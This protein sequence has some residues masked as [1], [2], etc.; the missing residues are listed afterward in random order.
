[1]EDLIAE[2]DFYAL[3]QKLDLKSTNAQAIVA[4]ALDYLIENLYNKFGYLK[5]L[6]EEPQKEIRHTLL[7][8]DI[9]DSL[10]DLTQH[11]ANPEALREVREHIKLLV[12][13]NRPVIVSDIVEQFSKQPYGWPEWEIV[14]LVAR[15]FMAREL[16]IIQDGATVEPK[17]AVEPMTKRAGWKTL[18]LIQRRIPTKEEIEKAQKLGKELFGNPGSDNADD[19]CNGLRGDLGKWEADLTAWSQLAQTGEYP[20]LKIIKQ[21]RQ[22]I[23]GVTSVKDTFEFI[24]AF[25]KVRNELLNASEDIFELHEFHPKS[26]NPSGKKLL[27]ALKKFKP[28]REAIID[29]GRAGN[30]LLNLES[31]F[32]NPEPYGMLK[33][34]EALIPQNIQS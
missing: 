24:T 10:L 7:A 21:C 5:E 29:D 30:A 22:V 31:I 17:D 23:N 26:K 18:K 11:Y 28:N 27:K 14:L 4:E 8:T 19:L 1:M 32:V 20:G 6:Q 2:A 15:L 12:A 33:D 16:N 34:V 9:N 25:N 13:K 3:G